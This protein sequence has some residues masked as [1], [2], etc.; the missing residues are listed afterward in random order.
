MRWKFNASHDVVQLKHSTFTPSTLMFIGAEMHHLQPYFGS[1]FYCDHLPVR[2]PHQSGTGGGAL[3]EER[4]VPGRAEGVYGSKSG[5]GEG[6]GRETGRG[7]CIQV[8]FP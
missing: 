5:G 3:F 8:K 1:T 2:F 7:N 4:A 6:A